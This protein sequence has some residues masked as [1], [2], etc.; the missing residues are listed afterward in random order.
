MAAFTLPEFL[1]ASAVFLFLAL[2]LVTSNLFGIQLTQVITPRQD[3]DAEAR[4]FIAKISEEIQSATNIVVGPGDWASVTKPTNS[5]FVGNALELITVERGSTTPVTI[6][7]YYDNADQTLKRSID[8]SWP[9]TVEIE[10][11]T[12]ATPFMAVHP[13][14]L[15]NSIDSAQALWP[16]NDMSRYLIRVQLQLSSVGRDAVPVGVGP[17]AGNEIR[18]AVAQRADG[19]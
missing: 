15:T 2:A 6:R 10:S 9:P 7:Y 16:S 13:N 17:F 4:E 3:A 14:S 12:N 19:D 11:V 8:G 5:A 18:F 1:I